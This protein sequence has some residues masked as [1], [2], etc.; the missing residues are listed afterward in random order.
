LLIEANIRVSLPGFITSESPT[1]SEKMAS[2][3]PFSIVCLTRQLLSITVQVMYT[4][5]CRVQ[6]GASISA[7]PTVPA[8]MLMR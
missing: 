8:Q 6:A 5:V 7:V 2:Y 3:I 1:R 4:H